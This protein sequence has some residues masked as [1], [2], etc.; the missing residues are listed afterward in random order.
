MMS[1]SRAV[2]VVTSTTL[3][4][5]KLVEIAGLEPDDRWEGG[6]PRSSDPR[7]GIHGQSGIEYESRCE[8]FQEP[9]VHLRDLDSRVSPVLRPL[10]EA[11]ESG[12]ISMRCWIYYE[13]NEL[14]AGFD[15]SPDSLE[16]FIS[17][18]CQIGISVD[19][20]DED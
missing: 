9:D 10:R 19:L 18:D 15:L 17:A 20:A 11:G 3:T 4:A 12:G 1:R 14:A 7:H 6:A 5:T 13:S 16:S 8:R 2:L